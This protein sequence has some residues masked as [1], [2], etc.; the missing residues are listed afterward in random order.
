MLKTQTYTLVVGGDADVAT[1]DS[2]HDFS[3]AT[4]EIKVMQDMLRK[5]TLGELEDVKANFEAKIAA[6]TRDITLSKLLLAQLSAIIAALERATTR[7]NNAEEVLEKAS[8]EAGSA[9]EEVTRLVSEKL[10]VKQVLF[11]TQS[12]PSCLQLLRLSFQHV[13]S[14]MQLSLGVDGNIVAHAKVEIETL[15]N[16]LNVLAVA[17][18][19]S[20]LIY[21]TGGSST[22][23]QAPKRCTS[24][25]PCPS[26]D[27]HRFRSKLP[28]LSAPR[29]DMLQLP[30][31]LSRT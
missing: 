19:N 20:S 18:A 31:L 12:A 28:D 1:E 26:K 16:K 23:V 22:R 9:R 4:L 24:A 10:C 27:G 3:K 7:R 8:L 13:L 14:D 2:V 6:A 21:I 29:P 5:I 15:F 11:S 30:D 25:Q 17:V